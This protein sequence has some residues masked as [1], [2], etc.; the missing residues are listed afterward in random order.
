MMLEVRNS[1]DMTE[2]SFHG[3]CNVSF[4][5]CAGL[6][7]SILRSWQCFLSTKSSISTASNNHQKLGNR[8]QFPGSRAAT[9]HL[10][11]MILIFEVNVFF[12]SF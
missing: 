6:P 10:L 1:L 2:R 5:H 12:S 8:I 7:L 4:Q 11:P 9:H 3:C